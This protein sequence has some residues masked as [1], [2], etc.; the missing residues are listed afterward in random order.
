[1]KNLIFMGVVFLIILSSCQKDKVNSVSV[2]QNEND[3]V[4]KRT[5]ATD[6]VFKNELKKIHH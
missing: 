4:L 2:I 6:D 1:M 5:C 3:K